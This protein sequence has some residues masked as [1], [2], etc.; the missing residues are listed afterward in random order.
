MG[1]GAPAM[2]LVAL[3]CGLPLAW[4]TLQAAINPVVWRDLQPS[5]FRFWLLA[6]TVGYNVGVAVLATGLALPAAIVLGRGR[7]ILSKILWA[8]L[9]AALLMP[10]LAYSY[11][12]SQFLV[13]NRAR[14][15]AIGIVFTPAG[16]A[17]VLRCVW[18]LAAW[19]WPVP[20]GL[21]GLAL[22][23]MDTTVQQQALLEGALWRITLR[24]LLGPIVAS[25]AI[26]TMLATQEFAI[27]ET[28]GIS[29]VATEVRMVFESGA[30]SSLQDGGS[31]AAGAAMP[32]QAARAAAA[33]AT[34]IPLL[35]ITLALAALAAWGATR[36]TAAS[37][38][39]PD[40]WPRRLNAPR[41]TYVAAGL[42][43][44]VALAVPIASLVMSLRVRFSIARLWTQFAPEIGGALLLGSVAATLALLI[45]MSAAGRWRG[46]LL[47][48]A[49][50]SF[51]IGGQLLAI[52]LVRICNR[53]HLTWAYDG[54][55]LPVMAYIGR[56]AWLPLV[57][58]RATWTEPWRELREL[59]ATDG[60]GP[61]RTARYVVW[62]L[63]W[64]SLV[65]AGLLV[66][67]LSLNEVPA[68]VLL[69]PLNPEVLTP[70]VMSWVHIQRY[71]AMIEASLAMMAIVI[72]P[73]GLAVALIA[74]GLR[75]AK[76]AKP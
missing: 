38:V 17:D 54:W 22:R 59:A 2:I 9:P 69:H 62:P 18:T 6:R 11:G 74:W 4:L 70:M 7:G 3:C 29:V 15:E 76:S 23:R 65:A 63:A 13:L 53:P 16:A 58:A 39:S 67:A 48:L 14:F 47:G 42:V 49:A 46:R 72:I 10:S 30:F 43:A 44:T 26:V 75:L 35:L 56:F 60:A 73:A 37:S 66:G 40:G 33:V 55:A 71:D 24:Q 5:S 20:A 19:L 57:A 41:W 52:A 61:L 25:L 28:T 8:I 1:V 36:A 45:A 34:A 27:Y 51:L 32:D 68:T 12:W 50:V 21:I 64:P 31:C